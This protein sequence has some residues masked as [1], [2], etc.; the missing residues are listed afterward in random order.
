MLYRKSNQPTGI[1]LKF[2]KNNIEARWHNRGLNEL[3]KKTQAM[4]KEAD[5]A[6]AEFRS[7][8]DALKQQYNDLFTQYARTKQSVKEEISAK[9]IEIQVQSRVNLLPLSIIDPEGQS[10]KTSIDTAWIEGLNV[11]I[12]SVT[13]LL[14]Q[15][16]KGKSTTCRQIAVEN[17]LVG[18]RVLYI[19]FEED[20]AQFI[21]RCRALATTY[22]VP[23][24]NDLLAQNIL[25]L[26][27]NEAEWRVDSAAKFIANI[28]QYF[29]YDYADLVI[30]DTLDAALSIQNESEGEVKD[31]FRLMMDLFSK[32]NKYIDRIECDWPPLVIVKQLK[33]EGD[34]SSS[35]GSIGDV[36][37]YI[38]NGTQ[39]VQKI[40]HAIFI[41][42]EVDKKTQVTKYFLGFPKLRENI[43]MPWRFNGKILKPRS[44]ILYTYDEK[45]DRIRFSQE[46]AQLD[47]PELDETDPKVKEVVANA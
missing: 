8:A 43:G 27:G 24:G 5:E 30:V 19:K 42:Y 40:T 13:T 22:N 3:W 7:D 25:I 46:I 37:R 38:S 29:T 21:A 15:T 39:W 16:N 41:D 26:N 45:T 20:D 36:F 18:K 32:W 9:R 47:A 34:H 17:A 11:T 2:F 6:A 1:R 31:M 44:H 4:K 33:S 28:D 10:D 14:A 35:P 12:G 23:N